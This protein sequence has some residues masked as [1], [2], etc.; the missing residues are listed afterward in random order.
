MLNEPASSLNDERND[1]RNPHPPLLADQLL[2][3]ESSQRLAIRASVQ[4]VL[5]IEEEDF[6]GADGDRSP[7]DRPNDLALLNPQS[8]LLASY[9]GRLTSNAEAAYASLD[10]LLK[11]D[12]RL[13]IFRQEKGKDVIHIV[14]GR[15]HPIDGGKWTSLIL[16][17][18]TVLS[19]LYLGTTMA[20]SELS[21]T[22]VAAANQL[23]RR[24]SEN[25]WLIFGE[26]WRGIPY[27][28]AILLILGA[29]ELGHY[30]MSRYHKISASLPYFIP[31]PFGAF[32]TF[33]AAIRLREPMRNRKML[34]DIG[35]AGPLA[36]LVF[37][38]PIVLI[39]LATS[40]V[41]PISPQGIVEGNSILYALAKIITF[42][43]F[44]PDGAVD[45]YV[46]QL[47]WAGWTGLFVTGLNLIPLGQLDGGHILY[48]LIG[49]RARALYYPIIFA[50]VALVALTGGTLL[51]L[52][53]LLIFLG[54]VY[55]VPLN[56]ITP[57]DNRRRLVAMF[58]L[59]VFVL[60]FVPIPLREYTLENAERVPGSS[61]ALPI[62]IGLILVR[63]VWDGGGLRFRRRA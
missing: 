13:P 9:H 23:I 59:A 8:Q 31:F 10:A 54:R 53:A 4:T 25:G 46:N 42:G 18:L 50:M 35:A 49:N 38:I 1:G 37:A 57:L 41:R 28:G 58:T 16:F 26:F 39:G 44:V 60:V 47:A 6:S 43:R 27:A 61:I 62:V 40:Q 45:V 12:D 24:I 29:H 22:N 2:E 7:T 14:Q 21:A 48:S 56:D 19:V 34:L 36:G 20:I 3:E 63:R 55:A 11:P 52:L 17:L 32:G 33:G 15:V 5:L 51:L 30:F